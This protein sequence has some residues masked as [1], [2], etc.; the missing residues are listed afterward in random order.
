MKKLLLITYLFICGTIFSQNAIEYSSYTMG[1]PKKIYKISLGYNNNSDLTHILIDSASDD[2]VFVKSTII[3]KKDQ[4]SDFIEYLNFILS[5][6]KEWDKI[7]LT[8]K[9]KEVAKNVEY[10]KEVISGCVYDN[11]PILTKT[12]L[13]AIY[14][15]VKNNSGIVVS[16]TR[17]S[18][19]EPSYIF[20]TSTK[21][22]ESFINKLNIEKLNESIKNDFNKKNLLK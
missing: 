21:S 5:K 9:I 11:G 14:S 3:L 15:F 10:D 8:N 20:F 4:L 22:L 19:V 7:N 1:N 17:N 12:T 2:P 13:Y 6:K 16:T 18:E